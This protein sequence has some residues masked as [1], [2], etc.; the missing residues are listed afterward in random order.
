ME[1]LEDIKNHVPSDASIAEI[2]YEASD[3]VIYTDSKQFFLNNSETVKKIVSELKKRVEVRPS[4]KLFKKAET[5]EKNIKDVIPER[6]GLEDLIFQPSLGKVIIRAEK[7]GKVIGSNGSRLDKIRE[8]SLWAPQVERVPSIN[9]KIVDKARELTVEDPEF[10]KEFLHE[11]GEK[12]RLEKSAG[13]EWIRIGGLGGCRQVG[14]SCFLL[15]TEESKVLMDAGIDPSAEAGSQQ[16]FPYLDAPELE[17]QDLDAVV[18]SHSHMD[19]CLTP[20]TPVTMA[21]GTRKKIGEVEEGDSL[22]TVNWETGKVEEARCTATKQVQDDEYLQIETPYNSIRASG[23]HRFFRVNDL[24]LEEV[25]AENLEEGDMIP[26]KQ[27]DRNGSYRVE[28]EEPDYQERI[29]VP[30]SARKRLVEKRKEE[31]FTQKEASRKIGGGENLVSQFENSYDSIQRQ[32]LEKLLELYSIEFERFKD[33]EELSVTEYPENLNQELSQI[34]GYFF[35]DGHRTGN[36]LRFTDKN[37]GCLEAYNDLFEEVFNYRGNIKEHSDSS[38]N[39]FVLEI[40]NLGIVRFLEQNIPGIYEKEV[41]AAV[42]EK[43]NLGSQPQVKGFLKGVFDAEGDVN[44]SIRIAQKNPENRRKIQNMLSSVGIKAS[45]SDRDRRVAVSS[46]AQIRKF[47]EKIGCSHPAKNQRMEK[48]HDLVEDAEEERMMPV[49][50]KDL[51]RILEEAGM[52]GAVNQSPS[53]KELETCLVDWYRRNEDSYATEKTV[54]TLVKTLEQRIQQLE[55]TSTTEISKARKTVSLTQ[56]E[57]AKTTSGTVSQIQQVEHKEQ[58]QEYSEELKQ[59][60]E[61][62]INQAK[63]ATR[64]N[65]RKLKKLLETDVEWHPIK[66][67]TENKNQKGYLVDIRV[68]PHHN[69]IAND[70]VVHNCGMIPYLYKMGYD[71]PLYCTKPT[72]DMMIM[73]CLDYIGIAH[74]EGGDAPYDSKAIKKAVKRTITPDYGE[75]T[76]ITPDMRLTLKNAGHILGSSLCHIHVGEGLHNILY[77]GD[78][79]YDQTEMLKPANTNFQRVETMITESTYGGK[80]DEQQPTEKA[81]KKFLSKMKQTLSKG[82]KVLVPV[83]AIGR[84]QEILGMLADEM[85]R[86]YFDFPVYMDGMINDANALHTAY[87]E[88]LSEKV[89]DKIMKKDDSPFLKENL[90]PVASHNERQDAIESGPAVILT[91]SGMVTGGPVMEYLKYLAPHE[92]NSM[93]FV[94]YQA[95]GTMGREIQNG[96]DKVKINGEEVEVN[97]DINTVSGFSAHSDRQQIINFARNLR[98]SPNKVLTNHGEEK[99]C[100]QLASTLHKALH[101]NT[102]APQNLEIDRLN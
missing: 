62:E 5:A 102:S 21:D 52:K 66:E 94:G 84:S 68:D 55:N 88:F 97:L 59:R 56:K 16:N 86:D 11:V 40:N 39:A 14:R 51:H 70:Q 100:F 34:I 64:Q 79:N 76:D 90:K 30:E 31:G 45:D 58:E 53:Y 18:L 26:R 1:E 3:I 19:H 61:Q 54:K 10:R 41:D 7:P 91:T 85:D 9:S 101:I 15:Q 48:L 17:L 43:I 6:A 77:T 50:S 38:K 87:P 12:I 82:G 83:F 44:E 96:A 2:R 29:K 49:K 74:S 65:V 57:I 71:G 27:I 20:E 72:R 23:D 73:N 78:Y 60:I 80:G 95:E 75:V 8:K 99:K 4:S 33:E 47:I 25:E 32:N 35:G 67:I 98:S 24:E 93:I 36:R 81:Q 28:L 63:Q 13:D 22:R 69:F 89:Q 37:Q 46:K 92:K 42:P